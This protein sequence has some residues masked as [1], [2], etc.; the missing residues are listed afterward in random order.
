MDNNKSTEEDMNTNEELKKT[1]YINKLIKE[2]NRDFNKH[3]DIKFPY[4]F[5]YKGY[6][7]EINR[8]YDMKHYTGYVTV[9][10]DHVHYGRE[11]MDQYD[12]ELEYKVHGGITYDDG[13]KIGF[14]CAHFGDAMPRYFFDKNCDIFH[15]WYNKYRVWKFEDVKDQIEDLVYQLINEDNKAKGIVP[16]ETEFPKSERKVPEEKVEEEKVEEKVK[17][18]K[19]I[20][21][22]EKNVIKKIREEVRKDKEWEIVDMDKER[23]MEWNLL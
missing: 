2:M 13:D 10:K 20:K 19:L 21:K 16:E 3:P 5:E 11:F 9:P 4:H 1:N 18:E 8:D 12:N 6:K 7:C 15:K 22:N 23:E 14:D 17:K